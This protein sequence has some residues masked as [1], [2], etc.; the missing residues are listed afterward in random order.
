MYAITQTSQGHGISGKR[1]ERS[2]GLDTALYKNIPFFKI[3]PCSRK[4]RRRYFAV[5]LRSSAF[6]RR[7]CTDMLLT[8][9][10]NSVN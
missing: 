4:K 3:K 8:A 10:N 9:I 5:M 1:F 6:C 2:N 7:A